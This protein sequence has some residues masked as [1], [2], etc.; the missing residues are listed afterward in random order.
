MQITMDD[1]GLVW[2]RWIESA[3]PLSGRQRSRAPS[4]RCAHCDSSNPNWIGLPAPTPEIVGDPYA[5]LRCG[6]TTMHAQ[7]YRTNEHVAFDRRV[8]QTLSPQ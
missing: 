5:C 8:P 2:A 7:Y 4:D 6:H 1:K 3:V